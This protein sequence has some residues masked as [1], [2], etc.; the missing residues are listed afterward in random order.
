MSAT[1]GVPSKPW[2]VTWP[3]VVNRDPHSEDFRSQRAAYQAVASIT[4]IPRLAATVWHWDRGDWRLHERCEHVPAKT[5][6]ENQ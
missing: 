5:T 3:S 4:R 1:T 2:R 6:G